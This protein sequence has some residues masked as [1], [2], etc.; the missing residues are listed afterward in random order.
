MV[1][2]TWKM[3]M[4]TLAFELGK[5]HPNHQLPTTNHP[6][7]CRSAFTLIEV[8]IAVIMIA[9]VIAALLQLF[10]TNTHQ[11]AQLGE[12][13]TDALDSTLLLGIGEKGF[14]K[15]KMRVE[16]LTEEFTLDDDLRRRLKTRKI[17]IDYLP[18]GQLDEEGVTE[19]QELSDEAEDALEESQGAYLEI[20]R[21]T[22]REGDRSFSLTRVR[23]LQ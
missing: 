17:E 15:N 8:M 23:L 9:V 1:I 4:K 19:D 10:A 13:V 7:P 2:G 16:D 12:K 3:A 14:E 11:T 6:T 5:H 18:T 22:M 20:G 21:T